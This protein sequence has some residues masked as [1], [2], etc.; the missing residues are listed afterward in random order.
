MPHPLIAK[1]RNT[2]F[3]MLSAPERASALEDIKEALGSGGAAKSAKT[4]DHDDRIELLRIWMAVRES[5]GA[6]AG[7][8]AQPA[9]SKGRR[10]A[11]RPQFPVLRALAG[12]FKGL[13]GADYGFLFVATAVSVF[14]IYLGVHSMQESLR[15]EVVKRDAEAIVAWIKDVGEKRADAAFEPAEC[16]KPGATT[17]QACRAALSRQGGP[18]FGMLNPFDATRPLFSPKCDIS[19]ISS[20]GSIVIDKGA[21]PSGAASISYSAIDDAEPAGKALLLRVTVCGRGFHPIK[22]AADLAF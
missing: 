9:K 3:A 1:H 5:A 15:I 20:V 22:V 18:A 8:A 6:G 14:V 10:F 19:D 4:L 16:R 17:W 13:K 11:W 7:H 12:A 21:Q 2:N